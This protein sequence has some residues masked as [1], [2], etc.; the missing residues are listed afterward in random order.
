MIGLP[1]ELNSVW[2]LRFDD[3]SVKDGSID[4]KDAN[5]SMI[6]PTR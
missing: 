3:V 2:Y 5:H 4:L 1:Y 6:K